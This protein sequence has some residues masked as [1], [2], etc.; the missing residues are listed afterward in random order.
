MRLRPRPRLRQRPQA[1]MVLLAAEQH[2]TATAIA[3]MGREREET[4]RRWLTRYRAEGV[5]GLHDQ[6]RGG[7]P[8]TVTDG[9]RAQ[10]PFAVR[11][12]PRRRSRLT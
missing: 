2:L 3:A 6:H 5:D 12:H 10:V 4:V 7:R 8:A 1:Q 9:Y 11:R